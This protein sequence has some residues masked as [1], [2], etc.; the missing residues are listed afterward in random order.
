MELQISSP[1]PALKASPAAPALN[2]LRARREPRPAERL[3]LTM[4]RAVETPLA[5][6]LLL[7]VFLGTNL[8]RAP[9]GFDDFLAI[10][11]T[12]KNLL[13]VVGFS[14]LWRLG[15]AGWRVYAW[16]HVR[17]RREE[18]LRLFG[19]CTSMSAIALVFPVISVT[20]AFGY[21]TV[22][23]FWL[24]SSPVLIAV[25][26]FLRSLAAG[27]V[28]PVRDV[29]IVGSGPRA[30]EL[31]ERMEEDSEDRRVVGF[32][33][34]STDVSSD[35]VRR[36]MLGG[37]EAL[38]GLLMHRAIDEVLIALPMKSCYTEIQETI[39][40]CQRVG[41]RVRYLA[42]IFNHVHPGQPEGRTFSLVEVP[43]ARD[44][45]RL[46]IKRVVDVLGAAAGLVLLS[47]L[48]LVV[49]A[50][51]KATSRGPVFFAGERYGY[52]RRRFRM[53]KFRTMVQDAESLQDR[54]ESMNEVSGPIFKIRNDPRITAVGRVLRRTSIDELPQLVNVLIG[55]MSLV[56][57]RP[58]ATRDV[59]RFTEAA[60]MRRFSV[61]PGITC[62]WQVS[63]RSNLGFDD[64]ITLDLRYIDQWSLGLDL[65]IL[66]R[67]IPA[68]LKGTG[69]A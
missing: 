34:T 8:V 20:G 52:N 42:D 30:L 14:A 49:A 39:A 31:F 68:V 61:R 47:P 41:V 56:G 55:D 64:W 4:C 46:L 54:Y 13:L 2:G 45:Y 40:V 28:A 24:V 50:A 67:T 59:Q 53:F 7:L 1:V 63:G 60:L 3:Y 21:A 36:R 25:R 19:L 65:L 16:H 58:M 51:I 12:V 69:A 35:L 37:P 23:T 10:R 27:N 26:A 48:F 18:A 9:G 6:L 44:D 32:V 29:L 17:T 15:A 66:L 57:P 38:E 43:I 62:L 22:I 11:V 5:V 33:D